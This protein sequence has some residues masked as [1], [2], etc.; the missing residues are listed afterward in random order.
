MAAYQLIRS[1]A[2]RPPAIVSQFVE[3]KKMTLR[4]ALHTVTIRPSGY[5]FQG[6]LFGLTHGCWIVEKKVAREICRLFGCD[7]PR[8]GYDRKLGDGWDSFVTNES[9]ARYRVTLGSKMCY[10][11]APTGRFVE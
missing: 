5:T 2:T 3:Q 10:D 7:L 8:C 6:K 9:D 11:V 1:P 4:R